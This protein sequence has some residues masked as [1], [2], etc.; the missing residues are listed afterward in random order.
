MAWVRMPPE[1]RGIFRSQASCRYTIR[2]TAYDV[3][4]PTNVE[5]I[6]AGTA[7]KSPH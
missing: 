4:N 6:A 5:R 1:A 3:R 7:G 2:V